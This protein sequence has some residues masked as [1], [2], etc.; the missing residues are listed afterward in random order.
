MQILAGVLKHIETGFGDDA[1]PEYHV[2]LQLR[3][4]VSKLPTLFT[5]KLQPTLIQQMMVGDRGGSDP[6]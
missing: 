3:T 1:L 5:V 2:N 6:P 4:L